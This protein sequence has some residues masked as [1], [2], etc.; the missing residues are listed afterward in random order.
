MSL[1]NQVLERLKSHPEGLTKE[2]AMDGLTIGKNSIYPIM[3]EIRKEYNLPLK[4]GR[5]I[6]GEK[7]VE[8]KEKGKKKRKYQRRSET[9]EVQVTS[10]ISDK[11]V[12]E[13]MTEEDKKEFAKLFQQ[14]TYAREKRK[15]LVQSYIST[16][17]FLKGAL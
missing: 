8:R 12:Y 3:S 16:Y 4:D 13:L 10:V 15:A 14:E 2:E 5:W 1:K 7:R 6:L 11:T 17:K 9:K